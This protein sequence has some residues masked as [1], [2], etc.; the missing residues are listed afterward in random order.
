MGNAAI[1]GKQQ[2]RFICEAMVEYIR[3]QGHEAELLDMPTRNTAD[4]KEALLGCDAV[5]SADE[6]IPGETIRFLGGRLKLISRFGVGT[7]EMDHAEAV[8]QGVTVCNAADM[9]NC[10]VAACAVGLL[11]C[12]MRNIH[13]SNKEAHA[14]DWSRFMES[15]NGEQLYDKTVGLV[16]IGGIAQT[17]A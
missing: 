8:R 12:L 9:L 3:Q 6:K 14:C 16:G 1:I 13:L 10:S 2:P 4:W 15:R 5:I 17:V 11:I 7:D